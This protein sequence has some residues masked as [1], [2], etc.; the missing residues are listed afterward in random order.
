MFSKFQRVKFF[1]RIAIASRFYP[2][3][4]NIEKNSRMKCGDSHIE[5]YYRTNSNK[6]ATENIRIKLL[7]SCIIRLN[8]RME[9]LNEK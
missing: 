4:Q 8:D 5:T 2:I 9:L 7:N 1:M 6:I 3:W